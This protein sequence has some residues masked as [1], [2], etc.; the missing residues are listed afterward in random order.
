MNEFATPNKTMMNI[1][2]ERTLVG[3]LIIAIEYQTW[4][5]LAPTISISR[6][7]TAIVD[8]TGVGEMIC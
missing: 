8:L 3:L 5:Q 4:M 6:G 2:W 1:N 7:N